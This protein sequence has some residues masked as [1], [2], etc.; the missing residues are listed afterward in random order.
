MH[1]NCSSFSVLLLTAEIYSLK[2]DMNAK[3]FT[4]VAECRNV[5]FENVCLAF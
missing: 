2:V 4:A 5:A 3:Y 1:V